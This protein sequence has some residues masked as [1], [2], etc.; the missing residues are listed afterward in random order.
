MYACRTPDSSELKKAI[1]PSGE[2]NGWMWASFV[3]DDR[4][5]SR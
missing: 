3:H 2:R 1:D 5:Q 4:G